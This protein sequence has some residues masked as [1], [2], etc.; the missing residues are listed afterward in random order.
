MRQAQNQSLARTSAPSNPVQQIK[1]MT[2]DPK[3]VQRFQEVIGKKA[4]QFLASIVSA[5]RGNKELSKADPTSVMAAAMIAA[6]L[7]LD[8]NP[9]L[10]FAAIVPY[11]NNK[12][13]A[14]GNWTSTPEAQF[15]M[16]TKGYVQL[17]LRSGQY[18]NLNVTEIYQDEFKGE[19]II[20][21]E[22]IV[23][24]VADGDRSHGRTSNIVGYVAYL[25]FVNGFR[26]TVYWSM[27]KILNHAKKFSKSWDQKTNRFYR[28]SAWDAHYEAMCKKTVLKN[29]LSS[30]GI[31]STQMQQ[32]IVSDNGIFKDLDSDEF[33]YPE[34]SNELEDNSSPPP[35]EDDENSDT[36]FE[37]GNNGFHD[38]EDIDA[39]FA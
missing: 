35:S 5:V 38:E 10:G 29:A 6:T 14:N 22:V 7:D 15:Q 39:L 19:D 36:T 21:G 13:D 2:T 24:P 1:S 28:G 12:K 26:K 20:S 8:I 25:E 33:E 31:L 17:A 30:W 4:P 34:N 37:E 27:E 18:R 16:M 23:D 11:K 32:A 3:I 9:N